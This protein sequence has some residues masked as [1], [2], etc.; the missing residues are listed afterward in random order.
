MSPRINPIG[1]PAPRIPKARFLAGPGGKYLTKR[2]TPAGVLAAA[3]KPLN[4]TKRI[5][6]TGLRAKEAARLL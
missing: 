1:C 2:L 6:A 3:P 5:K 4:A